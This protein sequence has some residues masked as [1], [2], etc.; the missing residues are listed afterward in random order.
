LC[1]E[2]FLDE[3]KR[4]LPTAEQIGKLNIYKNADADELLTLHPSD[5]LMVKLIQIDRLG[6]R[7]HGMLFKTRFQESWKLLEDVRFSTLVVF[8]VIVLTTIVASRAPGNSAKAHMLC[9]IQSTSKTC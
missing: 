3:L 5:R 7:V 8:H 4:V 2:T 6:P 1:T 9:C